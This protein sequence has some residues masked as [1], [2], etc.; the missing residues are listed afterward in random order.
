MIPLRKQSNHCPL[1]FA[2]QRLW[3]FDQLAP[4]NASYNLP[5]AVRIEGRLNVAAL[6]QVINEIARRHEILRTTFPAIEG[7]PVQ[8]IAPRRYFSVPVV[9]LCGVPDGAR[10]AFVERLAA[11]EAA[12][13]FDLAQGPLLRISLLR[14][15]EEEH[16]L[17]FTMHHIISDGGSADVLVHEVAVLYEVISKGVASPLPELPIQY[18]DFS[19][20]QREW[21]QGAVLDSQLAYWRE[22]LGGNLQDLEL[23]ADRTRSAEQNFRGSRQT[24]V[25][26]AR[27]SDAIRDLSRRESATLFMTL[28][29]AFQALLHRLTA[30]DVISVGSPI[31]GRN[32]TETEPLIGFFVNTLVLST[33]LSGDPSFRELLARVRE[34]I[35]QAHAHQDVPFEKLIEALRPERNSS[36]IPLVRVSFAFANA[37]ATEFKL[38]G[39]T[40]SSMDIHTGAI[41]LDFALSMMEGPQSL[42]AYLYYDTDLFDAGT[43]SRVLNHF[44]VLLEHVTLDPDWKLLDIPLIREGQENAGDSNLRIHNEADAEAQFIF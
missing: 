18:A 35:L 42:I 2:Q 41:R 33:D 40:L 15:A 27:L 24:L 26:S 43:I 19:A 23:P 9:E 25:L 31:S 13:P 17:L 36:R 4:G 1:S 10:E 30:Q 32:L 12:R 16:A 39:L 21:L 8:V 38:P 5:R 29:A 3:V 22:H 6:E 14:L 37:P 34:V 11:R 20:W 7:R 28:L 44:E